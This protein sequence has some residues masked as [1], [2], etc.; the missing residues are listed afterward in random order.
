ML[1]HEQT[2][3]TSILGDKK[4]KIQVEIKK[5]PVKDEA[6][7]RGQRLGPRGPRK[8]IAIS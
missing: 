8:D 6:R 7:T 4:H 5:N 3:P 2:K 1:Y